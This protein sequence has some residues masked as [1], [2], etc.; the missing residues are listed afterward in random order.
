MPPSISHKLSL[1][2]GRGGGCD[3]ARRPQKQKGNRDHEYCPSSQP[4]R[5]HARRPQPPSPST[6]GSPAATV[7]L[8]AN[9]ATQKKRLSHHS[10][11]LPALEQQRRRVMGDVQHVFDLAWHLA[12]RFLG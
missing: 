4:Q 2:C 3:A 5:M 10:E 8:S 11:A 6:A 1:V 9:A 12:R 7:T